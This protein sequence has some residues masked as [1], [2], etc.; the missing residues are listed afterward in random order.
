M[1]R[2]QLKEGR[3]FI[4]EHPAGA[5]SWRMEVIRKLWGEEGVRAVVADQ[6][7]SGLMSHDRWGTAPAKK[8]TRFLT[9]SW[10][11]AEA[12]SMRC[13]NENRAAKEWLRHVK[14]IGGWRA[15][16]AQ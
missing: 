15:S 12:L 16:K 6:C 11:V 4:H 1:Y 3:Y 13:Q 8:P 10:H 14:L 5:T 9:N 7:E 2:I